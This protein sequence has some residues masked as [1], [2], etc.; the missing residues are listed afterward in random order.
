MSDS[1]HEEDLEE[2]G[3]DVD[4]LFGKEPD[5]TSDRWESD[6]SELESEDWERLMG[7]SDQDA[8]EDYQDDDDGEHDDEGE[9]GILAEDEYEDYADKVDNSDESQEGENEEPGG[10]DDE[11]EVKDEAVVYWQGERDEDEFPDK[12]VSTV[13]RC[14]DLHRKIAALTEQLAQAKF[15]LLGTL[16]EGMAM[17]YG[18]D[19]IEI[20]ISRRH[21]FS[22]DL[23]ALRRTLNRLERDEIASG[24]ARLVAETPYVSI[25]RTRQALR[26]EFPRA[27][28]DWTEEE[29]QIVASEYENGT[30]VAGIAA[31]LEREPSAVR[32]VLLGLGFGRPSDGSRT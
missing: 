24:A 32:S 9:V 28:A 23:L 10:E 13:V 19:E 14:V 30:S 15:E 25:V 2:V 16:G 12:A 7:G 31:L 1:W 20:R 27:D 26:R 29:R 5:R 21:E 6:V 4:A 3:W 17:E 22:T 8:C 11:D 18:G